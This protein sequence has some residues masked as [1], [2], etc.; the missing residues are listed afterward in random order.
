[1]R[2]H[3]LLALKRRFET[4]AKDR[5]SRIPGGLPD[6]PEVALRKVFFRNWPYWLRRLNFY[7]HTRN[8]VLMWAEREIRDKAWQR[9]DKNPPGFLM[10]MSEENRLRE[11]GDV[12]L[13]TPDGGAW[14]AY[15]GKLH[16]GVVYQAEQAPPGVTRAEPVIPSRRWEAFRDGT[17]DFEM[18][19]RLRRAIANARETGAG[20]PAPERVEAVLAESV[21]TVLENA[22]DPGRYAR[23]RTAV[24]DSLLELQRHAGPAAD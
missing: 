7:N 6:D 16:Y 19:F 3:F 20:G 5:W 12:F 14:D 18:L 22:D 11:Y 24:T 10:E 9:V 8:D 23:V 2:A 4:T 21:A 13:K 15:E 1:M 17:E